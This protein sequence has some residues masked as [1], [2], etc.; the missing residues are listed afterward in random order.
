MYYESLGIKESDL[1]SPQ[2]VDLAE[3]PSDNQL[4][5]TERHSIGGF[6][7]QW[8]QMDARMKVDAAQAMERRVP[9]GRD[10]EHVTR[11]DAWTAYL[12]LGWVRGCEARRELMQRVARGEKI[13]PA[14]RSRRRSPRTEAAAGSRNQDDA[15]QHGKPGV[16][17]EPI[18]VKTADG[19][20]M[21]IHYMRPRRGRR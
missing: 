12:L 21:T 11:M 20:T 9:K 13:P 18:Q 7:R 6:L 10:P 8:N 3:L 4:T 17:I 2:P 16:I 14:P 5:D 15:R 1:A 19:D